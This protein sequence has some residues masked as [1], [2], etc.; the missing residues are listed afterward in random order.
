MEYQIR[1]SCM[2]F[3]RYLATPS[4][5]LFHFINNMRF[6]ISIT[7]FLAEDCGCSNENKNENNDIIKQRFD[8][9]IS[10][11]LQQERKANDDPKQG[12][13]GSILAHLGY[14]LKIALSG[15]LSGILSLVPNSPQIIA[16][17]LKGLSGNG[18]IGFVG[19]LARSLNAVF[20]ENSANAIIGLF[21]GERNQCYSI[22]FN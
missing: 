4:I 6:V 10:L 20:K 5:E 15:A 19:G 2:I 9:A 16:G 22:E 21:T 1:V 18:L 12:F 8:E 3:P 11:A 13:I 17:A 7:F 14:L